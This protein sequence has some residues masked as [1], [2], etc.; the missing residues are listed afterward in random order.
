MKMTNS[1]KNII[2]YLLKQMTFKR[3]KLNLKIFSFL[4]FFCDL[5]N[6]LNY[7]LCYFLLGNSR[8]NKTLIIFLEHHINI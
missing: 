1:T 3:I 7:K 4:R 8:I 6:I 5:N 2:N